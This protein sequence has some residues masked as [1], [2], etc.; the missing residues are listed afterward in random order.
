MTPAFVL[1][2]GRSRQGLDLI[3]LQSHGA[4]YGCNALY[5]EFAPDVLVA[6]DRPIADAIQASGYA[7]KNTFYTRR[8][9][10]ESGAHRIPV[11]YH[12]FS[13][14]PV[15]VALAAIHGHDCIYLLG[16]DLGADANQQFNNMYADTEFYKKTGDSPTYTG[17][18]CRQICQ[19]TR[20]F[21]TVNFV[22]V[23]GDTTA[24]VPEF[25]ALPNLTHEDLASFA[26]SINNL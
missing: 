4:V 23:C 16:F 2:N 7:L 1:G 12:G 21:P 6:T 25:G 20:D 3:Q 24:D 9:L 22:R 26:N 11:Q 10:A 13:S 14:G 17:N 15:A 18:W 8:P 19:I 5:R